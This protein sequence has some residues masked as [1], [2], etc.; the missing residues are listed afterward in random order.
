MHLLVE[1]IIVHFLKIQLVFNGA[2]SKKRVVSIEF[3]KAEL[4][5]KVFQVKFLFST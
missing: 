1:K 4:F 5:F 3:L 2:L